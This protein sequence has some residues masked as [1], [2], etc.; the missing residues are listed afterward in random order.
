MENSLL[1]L[2]D[3]SQPYVRR[4]ELGYMFVFHGSPRASGETCSFCVKEEE[5]EGEKE[6]AVNY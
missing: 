6:V 1:T 5:T 3:V 4:R 2:V